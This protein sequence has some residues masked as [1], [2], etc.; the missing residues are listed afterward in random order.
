V[1]LVSGVVQQAVAVGDLQG[2]VGRRRLDAEAEKREP[3]HREDRVAEPYGRLD[4][5]RPHHVGE[6]L[7]EH[8]VRRALAAQ[9]RRPRGREPPAIP[10]SIASGATLRMSLAPTRTRERTSRPRV[11]VPNGCPPPGFNSGVNDW[12]WGS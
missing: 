12:S 2:P 3:R 8:H 4:D 5:D 9:A 1:A 10:S 11:S 7:D 6:D